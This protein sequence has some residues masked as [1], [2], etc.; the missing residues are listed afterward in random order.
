MTQDQHSIE[1]LMA[2]VSE[3]GQ[4]RWSEGSSG[5]T[6]LDGLG[7]RRSREEAAALYKQ[8]E[9]YAAHL[10]QRPLPVREG[11]LREALEAI[12]KQPQETMS[13]GKAVAAMVRIA[14]NALAA[15]PSLP[16][17]AAPTPE[18]IAAG[19]KAMRDNGWHLDTDELA[20]T[21]PLVYA[22]MMGVQNRGEE[23]G[24]GGDGVNPSHGGQSE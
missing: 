15:S 13:D 23:T 11:M 5:A 7:E 17:R 2:L 8:I 21:M 14:R 19:V 3:Y 4:C 20:Q 1:G 16:V 12:L 22:A 10:Q 9:N 18:Q 24:T 6:H